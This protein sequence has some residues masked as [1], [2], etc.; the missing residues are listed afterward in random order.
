MTGEVMGSA[1]G[2]ARQWVP[3]P[4]LIASGRRGANS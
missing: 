2:T 3:D 1:T 4:E